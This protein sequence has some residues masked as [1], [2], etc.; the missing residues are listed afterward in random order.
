MNKFK[1]FIKTILFSLIL[2][3]QFSW[4]DSIVGRVGKINVA[5]GMIVVDDVTYT[6]SSS[7]LRESSGGDQEEIY[8]IGQLRVGHIVRFVQ[9]DGVIQNLKVL[10]VKEV[11]H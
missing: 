3:G 4:A 10:A 5:A 9:N 1:L 7:A 11:P 6:I 8:G 2:V